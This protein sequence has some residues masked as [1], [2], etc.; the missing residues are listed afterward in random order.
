MPKDQSV[1]KYNVGDNVRVNG[2]PMGDGV[3]LMT[4]IEVVYGR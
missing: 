2:W 4:S 3:V 1:K